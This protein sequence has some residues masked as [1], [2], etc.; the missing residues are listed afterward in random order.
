VRKKYKML[1]VL[2]SPVLWTLWKSRNILCFQDN[3]WRD[4]VGAGWAMCTDAA[5]LA[6][7][8]KTR[9][10]CRSGRMDTGAG[11]KKIKSCGA[12]RDTLQ[13]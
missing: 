9:R 12:P 10:G 11:K 2:S 13:R 5:R 4:F 8:A 7:A 3:Q 1:N 6:G